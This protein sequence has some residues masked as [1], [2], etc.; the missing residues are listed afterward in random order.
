MMREL[1]DNSFSC[2]LGWQ[3]GSDFG[4]AC[5]HKFCRIRSCL[6]THGCQDS[7]LSFTEQR[8]FTDVPSSYQRFRGFA[9]LGCCVLDPVRTICLGVDI[10]TALFPITTQRP[11]GQKKQCRHFADYRHKAH[12][13]RQPVDYNNKSVEGSSPADPRSKM[14]QFTSYRLP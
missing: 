9:L 14:E 12:K 1:R 5:S 2:G 13:N 4:C 8:P 11:R 10:L 6:L 7:N 3:R